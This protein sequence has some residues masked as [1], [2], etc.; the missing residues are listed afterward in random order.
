V[1]KSW[2]HPDWPANL[3]HFRRTR[4]HAEGPSGKHSKPYR[5]QEVAWHSQAKAEIELIGSITGLRR[6]LPEGFTRCSPAFYS[7]SIIIKLAELEASKFF[8]LRTAAGTA[9]PK[10]ANYHP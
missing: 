1:A 7:P 4:D 2:E 5:L 6:H 3:S 10:L 8:T 9:S